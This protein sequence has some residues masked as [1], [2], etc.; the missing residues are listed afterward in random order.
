MVLNL[1]NWI[2]DYAHLTKGGVLMYW[3]SSPP[4]HYLGFV[5][6]GKN[7]LIILPGILNKWAFMKQL[8]DTLSREGHPVYIIP[9]LK[10][11]VFDIPSSAKKV[12]ELIDLENIKDAIIVA[13]SKGGL[14]GKYLLA[15]N[16][17][18]NRVKG[19]V[20]IA[21]PFSGSILAKLIPHKAFRE[22]VPGSKVVEE[23]KLNGEVNK[24]IISVM[25]V[26]DNHVWAEEGSRLDGALDNVVLGVK[27]HHK[28]VFDK[29]VIDVI[30]GSIEKLAAN[31]AIF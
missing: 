24:K 13:H 4:E 18:D 17:A 7:S 31:C 14:I 21:T 28:I 19:M 8:A 29:K 26:Y 5:I 2:R 23:L 9:Q 22:L 25:P 10:N 15:F 11:N 30:K 1:I 12:R 20:A 27:G 3:H 6:E 16:N